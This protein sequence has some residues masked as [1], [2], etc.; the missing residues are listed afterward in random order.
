MSTVARARDPTGPYATG[1]PGLREEA[2]LD[3]RQTACGRYAVIHGPDPV[4]LDVPLLHVGREL[5]QR[6]RVPGAPCERLVDQRKALGRHDQCNQHR[7]AVTTRAAAGVELPDVVRTLVDVGLEERA[8]Q[9]AGQ[10]ARLRTEKRVRAIDKKPSTGRTCAAPAGPDSST[11]RT[12]P[13]PRSP[14][15]ADQPRR[16]HRTTGAAGAPLARSLQ[17]M[18]VQTHAD[19]INRIGGHR[20]RR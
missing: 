14:H 10:H 8:R 19:G 17:S 11:A 18:L 1:C 20:L 7:T 6:R 15:L 2:A 3:L 13:S 4:C 16:S 12:S 9:V 5:A